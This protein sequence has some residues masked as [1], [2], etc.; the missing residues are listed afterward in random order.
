MR[1]TCREYPASH[2]LLTTG[3]RIFLHAECLDGVEDDPGDRVRTA[4]SS[5]GR[6]VGLEN[7]VG[8]AITQ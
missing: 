1:T 7:S 6:V 3:A 4:N 5:N 8:V 2:I